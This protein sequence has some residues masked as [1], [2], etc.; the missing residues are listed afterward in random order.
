MIT[1]LQTSPLNTVQDLGRFGL[2]D[3]GV[4]SS[5]MMDPLALRIGNILLGNDDNAA[6]IEIQTYPFTIRFEVG[7]CFAVTGCDAAIMLDDRIVLPWVVTAARPGQTLTIERPRTGARACL[8]ISGGIEVPRI[9]GSR[10]TQLRGGF[11][12][13]DGRSL[14][15]DDILP[16]AAHDAPS[17]YGAVPPTRFFDTSGTETKRQVIAVRAIPATDFHR[18]TP[19]A[20]TAFWT[21]SWR[22]TPQ[23]DRIGYR[24]RGEALP[25]TEP[26]ELRSYG[27]IPGI[28]QVPPAGQPIVQMADANTAGGYPR[29]ACVIEADLWRLAQAP[30]GTA[31]QFRPCSHEEGAAAQ[32]P[33]N[34]YLDGL[35]A[36]VGHYRPSTMRQAGNGKKTP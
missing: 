10:S 30:I 6:A 21:T 13:L 22:I 20:Q 1:V 8:A 27:I 17:G 18:F 5:G 25:L 26:L 19:Q 28:V 34:R 33:L 2:R 23:S 35:R 14:Q 16:V 11:G 31:I 4:G 15:K 9:L 24:L 32:A 12:G 7:T 29:I 3:L 36:M